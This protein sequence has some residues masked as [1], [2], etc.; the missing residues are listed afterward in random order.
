MR[1]FKRIIVSVAAVGAIAVL[2]EIKAAPVSPE[3]FII[4]PAPGEVIA[5]DEITVQVRIPDGFEL[6][7]PGTHTAHKEGQ[8]HLHIWLDAVANHAG[9]TS[10]VLTDRETYTYKNVF[11][12]LHT[13][14]AEF[15]RNDH[16]RYDP[17]IAA[18]VQFETF[19]ELLTAPGDEQTSAAPPTSTGGLFL[20]PGG[21]NT[22]LAVLV[23]AAGVIILW[24]WFGRKRNP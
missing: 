24:Y 18:Q 14:Y 2:S 4:S 16:L 10:A 23:V 21:G 9:E 11:S 19:K 15:Y 1:S 20:P 5:S 13:I 6:V 3:L 8:G 7:D 17:P 12:G 22:V